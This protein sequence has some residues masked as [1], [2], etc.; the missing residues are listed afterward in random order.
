ME[1]QRPTHRND[2]D[3][4]GTHIAA[5][6]STANSTDCDVLQVLVKPMLTYQGCD[7]NYYSITIRMVC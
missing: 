3:Q 2:K 6:T 1:R 5:S 4:H 7:D